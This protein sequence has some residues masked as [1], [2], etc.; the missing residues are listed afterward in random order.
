MK[1]AENI[2]DTQKLAD[3]AR[4]EVPDLLEAIRFF[5]IHL[6]GKL[7]RV[8]SETD[9]N[10]LPIFYSWILSFLRTSSRQKVI[11]GLESVDKSRLRHIDYGDIIINQDCETLTVD[12]LHDQYLEYAKSL[13]KYEGSPL[14]TLIADES[15]IHSSINNE[16]IREK[17]RKKMCA[18]F[19]FIIEQAITSASEKWDGELEASANGMKLKK[20]SLETKK[21]AF[22][23]LMSDLKK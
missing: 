17:Y 1:L 10:F 3:F 12:S 4:E 2:P 5:N 11:A 19:R 9:K 7:S 8:H 21:E 23:L 6:V 18:F 15:Y 22:E 16:S 20:M 13:L 14:R